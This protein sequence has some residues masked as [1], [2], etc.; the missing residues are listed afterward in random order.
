MD[1]RLKKGTQ[2][3]SRKARWEEPKIRWVVNIIKNL[4]DVDYEGDRKH[5]PRIG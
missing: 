4:K 1:G 2:A 3:S 5:L